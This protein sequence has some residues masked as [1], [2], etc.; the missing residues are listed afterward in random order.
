M[1]KSISFDR[2]A[3]QPTPESWVLAHPLPAGLP[4]KRLTVDVPETLHRRI[5][6]QC[7][8]HGVN[9]ADVV[10]ELLEQR[11]PQAAS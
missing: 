7:A 3:K 1:S 4:T 8:Q 9:M 5:K 11:F 10:R 6:I 2:P